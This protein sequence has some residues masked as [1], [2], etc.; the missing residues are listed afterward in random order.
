MNVLD[1]PQPP[2]PE[3]WESF[4]L[5]SSPSY[6]LYPIGQIMSV[7]SPEYFDYSSFLCL[8]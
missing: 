4:I 6:L 7:L 1:P 5:D 2:K 3:T 8:H